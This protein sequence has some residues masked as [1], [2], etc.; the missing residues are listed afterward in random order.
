MKLLI[1][2][3]Y[4]LLNNVV[5]LLQIVLLLLLKR[6]STE[7]LKR[8]LKLSRWEALRSKQVLLK[9][10]YKHYNLV[11]LTTNNDK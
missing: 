9:K 4:L 8:L 7:P 10:I 2:V 11:A 6:C 5:L 3:C 1:V